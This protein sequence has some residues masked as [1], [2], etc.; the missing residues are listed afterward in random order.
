MSYK[1]DVEAALTPIALPVSFINYSGTAPQY[2]TY[3]RY[4]QQDEEF[5]ENIPIATGV[6]V[7]VDLWSKTKENLED[8][9][10]QIITA[11]SAIE[12]QNDMV[13]DL[14]ESD[15]K[16]CHIALRFNRIDTLEST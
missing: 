9:F 13:Q 11:M 1:T 10:T 5:A 4:N 16:M 15:I 7:Q 8:F 2:I 3:F 12:F 14:Y 6:Y